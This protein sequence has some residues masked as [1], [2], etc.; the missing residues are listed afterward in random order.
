[1]PSTVFVAKQ[2]GLKSSPLAAGATG[3]KVF[4]DAET[5][6][7]IA[8]PNGSDYTRKQTDD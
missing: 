6:V 2:Q 7:A 8:L 4:D 3:F 1:V 5:I